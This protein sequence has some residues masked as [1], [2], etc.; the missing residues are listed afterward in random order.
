[1]EHRQETP[2]V[3]YLD[4][5]VW[6][7]MARG[8]S[9]GD[10][11]W[12]AARSAL[13]AAVSRGQAVVP[14]AVAHYLELWHR[15]DQRS[16]EQVGA[17]IRDLTGYAT[18]PSPYLVRRREVRALVTQ[19]AGAP[20]SFPSTTDLLGHGAGHAFGSPHG[21]FRFVESLASADN[22]VSEGSTVAPPDNWEA[23]ERSGPAWEWLQLVGTQ[24]ILASEGVE[25]TPEHRHGT[26]HMQDE[27]RL[28]ESII[29]E[30][31]TPA[32]LWDFLVADE[33]KSLTDEINEIAAE[34]DVDPN[35][36]FSSGL[37]GRTGPESVHAFIAALPSAFTWATLRYRKHRDLT[38]PWEQHDWTDVSALSVAAPYCDV[39]IT[40]RRW[41][42]MIEATGLAKRHGTRAGHGIAALEA[43]LATL[44]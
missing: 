22:V 5:N 36:F 31:G 14:L 27:L 10:Q 12:I 4:M 13:E 2:V 6:V 16:R 3:V 11:R 18:I 40:E 9:Q 30:P 43:V 35:L 26:Q 7:S 33:L 23:L 25:R 28:R 32:Q 41:A 21:R 20:G 19:L 15:R 34:L 1:M 42:H 38:H 8:N 39:V 44:T 29:R 24:A 37:L 17:L